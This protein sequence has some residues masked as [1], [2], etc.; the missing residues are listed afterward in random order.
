VGW[1]G[2]RGYLLSA[3][4]QKEVAA[5]L[6]VQFQKREKKEKRRRPKRGE[7]DGNR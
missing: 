6:K 2:V 5:Q 3:Y 4:P 7:Y 1:G